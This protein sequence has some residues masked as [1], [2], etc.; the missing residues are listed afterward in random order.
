MPYTKFVRGRAYNRD[1][2]PSMS[3]AEATGLRDKPVTA[4]DRRADEYAR[5]AHAMALALVHRKKAE[6]VK[7]EKSR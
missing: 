5:A 4:F 1:H 6:T 3:M 2:L 7:Q